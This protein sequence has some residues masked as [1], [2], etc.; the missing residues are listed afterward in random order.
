[1]VTHVAKKMKVEHEP[2]GSSADGDAA[3]KP[4]NS[5][6]SDDE[7][8][9]DDETGTSAIAQFQSED[10]TN[11]GPQLEI[12][13]SSNV[14]Q[15]EELVNELLQNGK[16]RVP[17]SLFIGETEVTTS[18][19]ATVEELKLST[20][21]ALTIT[22]QPLAAFRVRPVT[23]CSDTLQG[24]SEA[25]LHVSFSPDGK[26]L[27]SG[28][29][30][31]TVR[32]WDT[33]TCMPKHTGRGH[34]NHVL[35]TAWSPD[36]TRFASADRNGEIRLWDPLTGKQIGQ[37]MKGHKQWVN[38]LTWE[39]M[40]RN[41]TCERFAS[42]SKDGSIKVWNARTGRS[43]ASLS[44]HTDS[45]ECIKWGGEGLLY[46]ASRDRTIKVWA[47]EGEHVGK[48]VRTLIGHGHRINTLAL[49][50]DYVCRSG[51][52]GHNTKS[53]AS[54]E[55]MQQAA[56]KRYQEV[57]KGQ[58]ERLVSGSDDFTLFFWEPSESKKP[59]ARLTG[60]QQPVNHLS[61]SPDGRY[62][63]SASFD[64]KVKIWNGQTGKFV[65][66][67]T[68]HVGAVYQVCWSSDSRLIVTASKDSTVK[69]WEL[70][71]PKNAKTTLSG[72]ADEVYALDWSP[73]GDMVASGSKDRTIKIW[74]H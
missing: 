53:F 25:I 54:R 68:G 7:E 14:R 62:F 17:Y 45:V 37:P 46:S 49:N 61:F 65:A 50:V 24:H 2:T 22:F 32:F 58:P 8:D 39:P 70:S 44:G 33:N 5:N 38:S 56:L 28:G 9:S 72:H 48:L 10:G 1:M 41:A 29:G 26:R 30:D 71:E 16:N 3:M 64:K 42:S 66:T 13:M 57:R 34:K 31:A 12:P 11:V 20:E 4:E 67:L 27:A 23:R 74:K 52:F 15:M 51:P 40:H 69:V 18:L 36:G 55:E 63:A 21:T 43:I 19:K 47:M 35:C 59:L 60:H 73:N 6:I